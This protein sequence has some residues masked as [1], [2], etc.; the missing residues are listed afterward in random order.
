[1]AEA[2]LADVAKRILS[3]LIALITEQIG[4]AWSFKEELRRLHQSVE[5]IQAVLADAE[6]RQVREESVRLWLQRLKDIAY[7]ADDLLDELDYEILWQKVE[8]RNQ[9]KRKV[10]FFFSSSNPISFRI[11]MANKIKTISESLKK[12]NEE[13]NG[14]GLT[15]ERLVNADLE[16]IPNRETDSSLD[17][18]GVVGREDHV[19]EI[20]DLLLSAT[21][22]QLL[23]ISIV[24]MAG[25]RIIVTTRSDKV[26]EIMKTSPR[27]HLKNLSEDECWFIIRKI[28]S[29]NE[30]N[31]L[32]KDLEVIG[33]HIAKKCGG[34]PLVARVLGGMMSHKKEK[35]E[36]LEIQNSEVWNSLHD[37][38]EVLPVLKLSFDNLP[39]SSLKQCFAYCS[40]FPKG[41]DMKREELIQLWM[42]EGFLQP[43]QGSGLVMEDIGNM[44]FDILLANSLFQDAKKDAYGNVI[45]C[46]MHD[47]VHDLALSISK[48]ETLILHGDLGG[49]INHIRHLFVQFDAKIVPRMPFLK[50]VKK[51]RT[52]VSEHA[53]LGNMLLGFECLRV[54]KLYG[55][56]IKV[57]PSSIGQLIH[58]RLLH[59]SST[60]IKVLPK[61]IT[62]LYNLQTLIVKYCNA[63]GLPKD[64]KKLI[65]LR[66]IYI[67]DEIER[68]VKYI[69]QLT[70]LQTYPCF[71][72]GQHAGHR[73]EELGPLNQLR[74]QLYIRSLEHVRDKKE[75]RGANLV[76]KDKIY[77][78]R[79]CWSKEREGNGY[80][81]E[82]VLEGLQPHQYLKSL[83]IQNYKGKKFPSW[84]LTSSIARDG[85][86]LFDNLIEI[87]LSGCS[88]CEVLPTLGL[89]PCLKVLEISDMDNLRCIDTKFYSNF[90]DGSCKN[91][92]FPALKRLILWRVPNL[93]EW[94][95]ATESTETGMVFPC[96]EELIIKLCYQLETAPCHFPSL[97]KLNIFQTCSRPFE[98]ICSKLTTLESLCIS[99]ILELASLP[100]QLLQ[101]N[102]SL[103]DL[104]IESCA[105]LESIS[106]H[107]NVFC[108]SLRSLKIKNCTKLSYLLHN[109]ISLEE[110]KVVCCPNLK[111]FPSIEIQ[112]VTSL[113]RRLEISECGVEALPTGLQLCTS[114]Q[115]LKIEGGP[116]LISIAD[117]GEEL[118]SLTQLRIYN[119]PNLILIADLLELRSLKNLGV[120]DCP[121][122]TGLSEGLL[123]CLTHLKSLEIG[124][125]FE[126][127]DAFPSLN[128]IQHSHDS[129]EILY[130]H[131]WSKLNSLPDKI[132]HFISLKYLYIYEFDGIEVLPEWLGNLSSLQYLSLNS[133]KNLMKLPT[134]QA[135]RRLRLE[136]LEI[137][138]CPKLNECCAKGS[139]P[140]W[141]KIAHIPDV[142]IN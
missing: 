125:Y 129:L 31:P 101:N 2:I 85:F 43:S 94:K 50:G 95:D 105:D 78:L 83:T 51:L 68:A 38:N 54:L 115:E 140:E 126:E 67:D 121:K 123:D 96:L 61:S 48:F 27:C 59:L 84:M 110:L 76:E 134:A 87:I 142:D 46:K 113:L 30:R 71:T 5:M 135:M 53:V 57:L 114:L 70:C 16:I 88:E 33:R 60:S 132:Q 24:G 100:E 69:G 138:C 90:N 36:W 28:V 103:N 120:F 44:Y 127:L 137:W 32:T 55:K 58:L 111:S 98:N 6:K 104:K 92:L 108:A 116:N 22:Q 10:H 74:G 118:H 52:F 45:K 136:K 15:K 41:Y 82:E 18:S 107:E 63:K 11:K 37:S 130:L 64:L 9:M 81:D 139:G 26:A 128:S 25:N 20:V 91:V 21:D 79:F 12:I 73:I 7:E 106:P 99:N 4:L 56:S 65:N 1:M 77:M 112:D 62:K 72:V 97:K 89:L 34:V 86:S 17:H 19:S 42:A 93:V 29:A 133:C 102:C 39:S 109:F 75:A 8:I 23:V 80:N 66:H 47:L 117:L 14:F 13:A 3:K 35:N 119:C 49:D 141:Y 122:L 124:G 131:G 40:I